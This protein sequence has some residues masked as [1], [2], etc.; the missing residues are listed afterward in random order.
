MSPQGIFIGLTLEELQAERLIALDRAR[1]GDRTA[2]SG[3]AKSSSRNFSLSAAEALREI[4]FAIS[5]LTGGSP[6][7]FQFD[8]RRR[9]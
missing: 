3:A 8:A 1:Y 9:C 6:A 4:N 7:R 5:Q 2:L